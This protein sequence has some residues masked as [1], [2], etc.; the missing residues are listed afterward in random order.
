[1][2][3]PRLSRS[4]SGSKTRTQ[5]GHDRLTPAD[6]A[7]GRRA[8]TTGAGR[9]RRPSR[10]PPVRRPQARSRTSGRAEQGDRRGGP[11]ATALCVA[12][13][14]PSERERSLGVE[15]AHV[16]RSCPDAWVC[17]AD[18]RGFSAS[19]SRG[20]GRTASRR[21]P[22]ASQRPRLVRLQVVDDRVRGSGRSVDASRRG[23][24]ARAALGCADGHLRRTR[25]P[26][27]ARRAVL[28]LSSRRPAMDRPCRHGCRT[29]GARAD[30]RPGIRHGSILA[31]GPDRARGRGIRCQLTAGGGLDQAR[32]FP[33]Q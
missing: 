24:L 31:G 6:P 8:A 4:R 14:L 7:D 22:S 11:S 18:Q 25:V 28:R 21:S 15:T 3:C 32:P 5:D 9:R 27:S 17:V 26:G 13:A 20:G 1:M 12:G 23:A 10:R 19:S 2:R 29:D 16:P 30:R 33:S